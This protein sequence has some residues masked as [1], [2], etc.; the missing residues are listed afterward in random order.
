MAQAN[1]VHITDHPKFSGPVRVRKAKEEPKQ[2][3]F[4]ELYP[5]AFFNRKKRL[6][7]DV[8]PSGNYGVDCELGR[9]YAQQFIA[10]CDGTYGWGALL[11]PIVRDMIK[12]GDESGLVVGFM[13]EISAAVMRGQMFSDEQV[14]YGT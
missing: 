12:S 11:G 3:S 9:E 14:P 4:Y 7:W 8:K 6:A 1:V 13:Q 10:S 2:K 5:Q